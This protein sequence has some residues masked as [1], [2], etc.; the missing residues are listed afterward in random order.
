V[1]YAALWV[2]VVAARLAFVYATFHSRQLDVW[3]FTH[4]ISGEALTAGFIFMAAGLLLART[5][6]LY[7]RARRLPAAAARKEDFP[8]RLAA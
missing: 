1:A 6:S 2:A 7:L 3:L 4:R 5:A 8:Q